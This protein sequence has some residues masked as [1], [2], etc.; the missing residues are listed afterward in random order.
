MSGELTTIAAPLRR[1][2]QGL[3]SV[4]WPAAL[5]ALAAVVVLSA[6][7]ARTLGDAMRV[8][9]VH[10]ALTWAG[11]LGLAVAALLGLGVLVLLG[12][13]RDP[14]ALGAEHAVVAL[15]VSA[16]LAS[17]LAGRSR[18]GGT[19]V[20]ASWLDLELG[21]PVDD[22]ADDFIVA[23]A[24]IGG[25][26]GGLVFPHPHGDALAA[27]E[28]LLPHFSCRGIGGT[29]FVDGSIG[30]RGRVLGVSRRLLNAARSG[31]GRGG[32]KPPL[33]LR[34][35]LPGPAGVGLGPPESSS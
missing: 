16:L 25:V 24:R 20:F 9:Y 5:L 23:L 34:L 8:V 13:F 21:L 30:H 27:R 2:A 28:V 4:Q 31:R 32:W 12:L 18:E 19:A 1:A 11:M 3:R 35:S 17:K 26:A 7:A 14:R 15:G 33:R 10:V 22:V 29:D 6:P